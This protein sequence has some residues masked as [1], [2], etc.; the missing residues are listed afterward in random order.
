M[1]NAIESKE[2]ISLT[3]RYLKRGMSEKYVSNIACAYAT[4]LREIISNPGQ[5]IKQFRLFNEWKNNGTSLD[6]VDACVSSLAE[7]QACSSPDLAA[8]HFLSVVKRA[9]SAEVENQLQQIWAKV[10]NVQTGNI[11]I[12]KNFFELGGDSVVAMRLVASARSAG[13]CL[14][15]ADVFNHPRLSDLS[16]LVTAA[17]G[18]TETKMQPYMPLKSAEIEG[19][20]FQDAPL[21]CATSL[22]SVEIEK[23]VQQIW[24]RALNVPACS[25]KTSDN[26]FKLGGDS[27]TAMRSVAFARD[28]DIHLSVA[29]KFG[30]PILSDLSLALSV[31]DRLALSAKRHIRPRFSSL[32]LSDVEGFLEGVVCPQISSNRSNIEDALVATDIQAAMIAFGLS[33]K[34]GNIHYFTLDFDGYVNSSRLESACQAVVSHHPIFRTVF[35]AHQLRVFQIVLRSVPFEFQ[36]YKCE[37]SIED[38]SK[39]LINTDKSLDFAPGDGIVR[40]MF[41]E[42][43]AYNSRLIMKFS[44]AQY[45]GLCFPTVIRDLKA[46][47]FG[48]RIEARPSFSDF[49]YAVTG[50]NEME[51]EQFWRTLLKNSSMTTFSHCKIPSYENHIDSFIVRSIPTISLTSQGIT[52]ASLAKAAWAF[53]LAQL[54][55]LDDVVFGQ[56]VSGR[57]LLLEG[58]DQIV[59]P[60]INAV[61]VRV[62]F[63]SST[64]LD[65]LH[66]VQNQHLEAIPFETMGF[67]HIVKRCTGWPLWS[68]FGSVVQHQNLDEI[69]TSYRFGDVNCNI[70]AVT[71]PHDV[72]DIAILTSLHGASIDVSL[73]YSKRVISRSFAEEVLESLC[74]TIMQFSMDVNAQLPSPSSWS[75]PNTR[76]PF[77]SDDGQVKQLLLCNDSQLPK[78]S[79]TYYQSIVERAWKFVLNIGGDCAGDDLCDPNI[80]FFDIWGDLFAAA[81]LSA[82]YRRE[83]ICITV[84]E[85]LGHPTMHLQTI[86]AAQ[87]L[88]IK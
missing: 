83:G 40:F 24:A 70:G 17:E 18:A 57:N 30:H 79:A 85:I 55:G 51:A 76:I 34:R 69:L 50:K 75:T 62:R 73:N 41:L 61:P 21:Q 12:S 49:I 58:I 84:E 39:Q 26:F 82:F 23:Q 48:E 54:S 43:G 15:M 45:D 14:S 6:T 63:Q 65:L 20:F 28:V 78:A 36:R 38:L 53:V 3:L 1:V 56:V 10:L 88:G 35:F 87:R 27:F 9:P 60:C 47:Y 32:N 81:Q 19:S 46:A 37:G 64:V 72:V 29:D 4:A 52:F 66:L 44:H 68:R 5:D 42:R 67:L 71:A 25:I 80:P 59:G 7:D 33:Q 77:P 2:T 74:S 22:T 31:P 16:R 8:P 13:I 11:G 86:L